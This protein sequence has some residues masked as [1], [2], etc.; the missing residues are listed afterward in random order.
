MI[1]AKWRKMLLELTLTLLPIIGVSQSTTY[2]TLI[3]VSD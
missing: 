3:M 2:Q 1:S